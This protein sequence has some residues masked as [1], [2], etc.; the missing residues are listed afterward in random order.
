MQKDCLYKK[1]VFC[2]TLFLSNITTTNNIIVTIHT[3]PLHYWYA[4]LEVS[5]DTNEVGVHIDEITDHDIG[6]SFLIPESLRLC[7]DESI[8]IEY[9]SLS[10][11]VL[12]YRI[13]RHD[14]LVCGSRC[15]DEERAEL[16][17]SLRDSP[18]DC[19]PCIDSVLISYDR[20]ADTLGTS[21]GPTCYISESCTLNLHT[22]E[23]ADHLL[24]GTLGESL[25]SELAL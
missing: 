17:D 22:L 5:I 4:L 19:I 10:E 21:S 18:L 20:I 16:L 8:G 13:L 23:I 3:I 24:Y 15:L 6:S 12:V 14:E 11:H 1:R 2:K 9:R 25:A 7:L